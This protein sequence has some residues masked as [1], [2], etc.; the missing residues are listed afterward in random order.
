ME[1]GVGGGAGEG[2]GQA[3]LPGQR[4]GRVQRTER[5]RKRGLPGARGQGERG[6]ERGKRGWGS[7]QSS[8]VARSPAPGRVQIV[9]AACD[10]YC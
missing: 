3:E 8:S 1:E 9:K 6:K 4:A 2:V 5:E 10:N 7:G